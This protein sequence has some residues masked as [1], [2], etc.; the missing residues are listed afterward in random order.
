MLKHHSKISAPLLLYSE[1][2]TQ[3]NADERGLALGFSW[4]M[5]PHGGML[6]T[7]KIARPLL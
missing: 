2:R 5:V 7:L 3:I 4:L 6:T 1:N